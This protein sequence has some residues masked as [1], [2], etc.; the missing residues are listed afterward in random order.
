MKTISCKKY[1]AWLAEKAFGGLDPAEEQKLQA[2]LAACAECR[3]TLAEMENA[4]HLLGAL[5]RPEMPEHFWEGYWHRLVQRMERE[6]EEKPIPLHVRLAEW[7][8]E[9]WTTQPLLIPLV[10]TAGILALLLLGVL[11]GHYWWPQDQ[12]QVTE[13]APPQAT[14]VQTRV[15]RW[16]DRSKVL[17]VGIMNEDLSEAEPID[18]SLQ[19][20]TSRSLVTEARA[21]SGELDP[22]TNYQLLQL[23]NQLELI[24]L[25]IANLEAEHDLTAV[26]LV[27]DGI[28]REG[29]LFK[30]NITKMMEQK[31]QNVSPVN[32]EKKV[33]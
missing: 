5:Q 2:H 14:A 29:L 23:I 12:P 21:L 1:Q 4:L 28:A 8:R 25:Q 18:F 32:P 31:Q 3:T 15:D 20:Q 7:L 11:I 17:L 27:R 19:R 24:L 6:E 9:K 33:L 30:I 13:L 10:R 26:E 22:T 16:L